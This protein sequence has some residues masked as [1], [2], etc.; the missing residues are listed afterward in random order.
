[1]NSAFYVVYYLALSPFGFTNFAPKNMKKK[2]K[3]KKEK[4]RK[5]LTAI[6]IAPLEKYILFIRHNYLHK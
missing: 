3:K 4:K 5:S 2:K 6:E 1:M